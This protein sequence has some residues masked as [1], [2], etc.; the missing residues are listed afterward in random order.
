MSLIILDHFDHFLTIF[1]LFWQ[2][3]DNFWPFLTIFWTFFLHFCWQNRQGISRISEALCKIFSL[4]CRHFH[5]MGENWK[6]SICLGKKLVLSVYLSVFQ[7]Q[8]HIHSSSILISTSIIFQYLWN[9]I[10][11]LEWTW[12]SLELGSTNTP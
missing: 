8:P 12:Q 11:F 6:T 5:S 1:D 9:S 7:C 3:F 2:F 10:L 4:R